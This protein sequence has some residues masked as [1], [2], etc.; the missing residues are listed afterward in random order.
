MASKQ[1][2]AML[3]QEMSELKSAKGEVQRLRRECI[4]TIKRDCSSC[5]GNR[6]CA[7]S[8]ENCSVDMGINTA[9]H[10]SERKHD[11]KRASATTM[12]ICQRF[13]IERCLVT[14]TA[15]F[16]VCRFI[17]SKANKTCTAY[18]AAA[19]AQ[20]KLE[21]GLRWVRQAEQFM[22]DDLFQIHAISFKTNVTSAN[23]EQLFMDTSL[24]VTIFGQKQRLEGLRME[25]NEFVKLS[26]EIAKYAWEWYQKTQAK[27]KSKS[28][29][30]D[31]RPRPPP[32]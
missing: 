32:S 9:T 2:V 17:S 31:N 13:I 24:E 23:L 26:S 18:D 12:D 10:G 27:S 25:F 15:C 6:E 30:P 1:V 20:R 11:T 4:K 14:E 19:T 28:R 21:R 16:N 29:H 5:I 8:L 3:E 7:S 22:Y